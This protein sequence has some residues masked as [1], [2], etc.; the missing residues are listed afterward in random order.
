MG[1]SVYERQDVSIVSVT[2]GQSEDIRSLRSSVKIF[3]YDPFENPSTVL[4]I[5][6]AFVYILENS[7][8]S[9]WAKFEMNHFRDE[10]EAGQTLV[11]I[12]FVTGHIDE[13][14]RCCLFPCGT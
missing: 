2:A 14:H 6:T 12:S 3:L 11:H 4:I 5:W 1:L 10:P 13:Q 7:K 8:S 9:K